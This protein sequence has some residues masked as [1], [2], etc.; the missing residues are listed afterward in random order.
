MQERFRHV[1]S[2]MNTSQHFTVS[3]AVAGTVEALK[4][5]LPC[6]SQKSV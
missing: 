2:I 4:L 5:A 3:N 6:H 1:R